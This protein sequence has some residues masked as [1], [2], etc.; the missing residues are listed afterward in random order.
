MHHASQARRP[1]HLRRAWAGAGFRRL[2]T[3]RLIGQFGDGVFQASLAGAVLFNPDHQARAA[4]V[5]AG[6]AVLLVPYSVIGPFAGVLLDRWWRQ[7]VLVWANLARALVVVLVALEISRAAYAT[8][9]GGTPTAGLSGLAFYASALVAVSVSRFLNSALSASLPH[10]VAEPE[11][12]TANAVSTTCG[13]VVT[14]IG[15]ALA[16]GVRAAA[17]GGDRAYAAVA[18]AALLPYLVSAV[19]AGGFGR[20]ALGPDEAERAVRETVRQ[21]AAGLLAGARHVRG[22]PP[23]RNAL[24]AIGVHRLCFGL[25]TVTTL[26]LYR[27]YFQASGL[28]RSG[29][30]GLAQVVAAVAI[31]GGVAA[32]L[33]PSLARR[34]GYGPL[35]AVLLASAGVFV[36]AG[37]LPYRLGAVVA[38]ALL[39]GY[40][41]QGLKICVDTMVQTYVDDEFRGRVFA[42]YDALFNLALVAAAV[43]TAIA[44]PENGHS[45]GTVVT[46]S[47]V[48][49]LSGAA[50]LTVSRARPVRPAAA[51]TTG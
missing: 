37:S 16:V 13:T 41:S 18:A 2:L 15:G 19:A 3:V 31:G 38:S 30:A 14:T 9:D 1:G 17:G 44:L 8:V 4:D 27:N 33:T 47:A 10:V 49:L 34:F 39:L 35:P 48:Y 24:A 32:L 36:A 50:Y 29:L 46:I 51:R 21:I 25:W 7:R 43:L 20:A 45:P 42:L 26:L 23:A 5:A 6:F 28:L 22:R 11:L 12:V 40:A